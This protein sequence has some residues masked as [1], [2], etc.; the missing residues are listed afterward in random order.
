MH[1]QKPSAPMPTMRMRDRCAVQDPVSPGGSAIQ[2]DTPD[3]CLIGWTGLFA[4]LDGWML[5]ENFLR[6]ECHEIGFS[7]YQ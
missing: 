2:R 1:L 6:E 5:A 7:S 3:S 4:A